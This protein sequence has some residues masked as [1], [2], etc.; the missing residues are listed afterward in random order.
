MLQDIFRGIKETY[1]V[2]QVESEYVTL[3]DESGN[4]RVYIL[5]LQSI[6]L[7]KT[8]LRQAA[9]LTTDIRKNEDVKLQVH[10]NLLMDM[11]DKG[12]GMTTLI[13]MK[14]K[15]REKYFKDIDIVMGQRPVDETPSII[16][17]KGG[18]A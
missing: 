16:L 2:I 15:E 12:I 9:R 11:I 13:H 17:A 10:R 4:E 1:K 6:R 18:S 8:L 7:G 14:T 3:E 5:K